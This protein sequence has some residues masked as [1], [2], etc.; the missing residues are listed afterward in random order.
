MNTTFADP[1]SLTARSVAAASMPVTAPANFLFIMPQHASEEDHTLISTIANSMTGMGYV[2]VASVDQTVTEDKGQVRYLPFRADQ[3][4]SFG[5]V[6]AVFVLRDSE[7]AAA[8]L[9]EYRGAE[10]FL[11]EPRAEATHNAAA[12]MSIPGSA[13]A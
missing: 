5:F 7:V 2:Y 8:A 9:A 12:F 13:T 3:F 11:L 6:N 10:G 1:L 4:P